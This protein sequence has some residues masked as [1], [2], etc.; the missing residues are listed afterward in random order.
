MSKTSTIV[1]APPGYKIIQV[2]PSDY[3]PDDPDNIFIVHDIMA[4]EIT[5]HDNDD[6]EIYPITLFTSNYHNCNEL[7]V[8]TPSGDL[9]NIGS[10]LEPFQKWRDKQIAEA[11]A[12]YNAGRLRQSA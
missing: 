3:K 10:S 11:T 12:K 2:T 9:V 6:Y 5:A 8:I 4:F 7:T 1:A